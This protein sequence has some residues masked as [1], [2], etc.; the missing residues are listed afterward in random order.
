MIDYIRRA[1]A[2]ARSLC[3][4]ARP[5][6]WAPSR[7]RIEVS[8]KRY[9]IQA[10]Q[11]DLGRPVPWRKIFRLTRRAN[12]FYNFV[13]P[14]SIRGALA[15][16]TNVGWDAVDAAASRALNRSQGGLRPVSDRE[17]RRRTALMRTAKP[18]GPGTR[19]WCQVRGG[20]ID[21]SG[22]DQP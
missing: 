19:C 21:P 15:I 7:Q 3:G 18:C 13:H 14:V 20:E 2:P 8:P 6:R 5:I 1:S 22:F 16:V 12:H 17:A 10:D 11:R 4:S 9:F